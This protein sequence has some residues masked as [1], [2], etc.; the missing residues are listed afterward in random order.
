MTLSTPRQP[1]RASTW[2]TVAGYRIGL[3]LLLALSSP[4]ARP[5][6][7]GQQ[8]KPGAPDNTIAPSALA[9]MNALIVDKMAR[10]PV[11]Q[12]MDSNLIYGARI[13]SGRPIV[14]GLPTVQIYLPMSA[15]NRVLLDVRAKVSDALLTQLRAIGAEVTYSNARYQHVAV[16]APL[17][18]VETI[19]GMADV[20][21]VAPEYG[22]MTSNTIA[23]GMRLVTGP[24]SQPVPAQMATDARADT[25]AALRA[26]IQ[27]RAAFRQQGG[28]L[29]IGPVTSQ[30]DATHR[31][32]E[33]RST[34]GVNGTGVK[35]GVLSDGVDTLATS[36]CAGDLPRGDGPPGQAGQRRRRHGDARDRP[37]PRAR[38]AAVLRDGGHQHRA[39][40]RRTSATCATAGC[41]IIVDDVVY[42]VESPFQDGQTRHVDRPTAASSR[43]R[44]RT[45]PRRARCTSRRRATPGDTRRRHLG[46]V[47]GRLRRRR[48]GRRRARRR[49]QPPQLRLGALRYGHHHGRQSSIPCSGR[50]RSAGRATTTISTC[51]TAP[52][53]PSW[54]SATPPRSGTQDP[55]EYR[56]RRVQRPAAR[57]HEVQRRGAIPPP[58]HEPRRA[59]D[60]YQRRD[61][62]PRGDQRGQH[63]RRRRHARLRGSGLDRPLHHDL[64][65]H[66]PDRD[67]Q[68]GRITP[69]LFH[70]GRRGHHARELL[71]DGRHGPQ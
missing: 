26:A 70:R 23:P 45:S 40:S 32:A 61:A 50:I 69:H 42:F 5:A 4:A 65:R 6:A 1:R 55:F 49:R 19:A 35:I 53:P 41:D 2:L 48:S 56:R 47:G 67:L 29:N 39:A 57:H 63:L 11:Q 7:A 9:Q 31:A 46:H 8:A 17:G 34:F 36:Q 27:H 3:A 18:I 21:H 12:K 14:N 51:S 60:C 44:S 37:R 54:P 13:V 30:G 33:A 15:D 62:R 10:S 52:V 20:E 22:W 68:L 58:R 71:L 66:Q 24:L 43:R 64:C 25:L 38:R 16:K 59:G 28:I